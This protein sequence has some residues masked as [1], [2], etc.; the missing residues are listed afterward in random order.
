MSNYPKL[1]AQEAVTL[2]ADGEVCAMSGFSGV[3][4]PKDIP[5]AIAQRA[6][7]GSKNGSSFKIIELTGGALNSQ[8]DDALARAHAVS[9]CAPCQFSVPMRE[10]I[11]AHKIDYLDIHLSQMSEALSLCHLPRIQTAIIEVCNVSSTG[12]LTLTTSSGCSAQFCSMADR[13]LLELNEFHSKNLEKIHDV[14]MR[15]LTFPRDVIPLHTLRDRIGSS[16]LRV[17][18]GKIAGVVHTSGTDNLPTNNPRCVERTLASVV[19]EFLRKELSVGKLPVYDGVPCIE[20]GVGSMGDACLRELAFSE[21]FPPFM[22]FSPQLSDILFELLL[23]GRCLF[24]SGSC[25]AW[26]DKTLQRFY[27]SIDKF[28][29]KIILRPQDISNN[30]EVISRFGII[31]VNGAVEADICG[32][33]NSSHICGNAILNGIGGSGDFARHSALSIFIL[34]SVRKDGTISTIVPCVAHVD[35]TEHDVDI[36]I[37]EQ[38]IADLRGKTP[39][40]RARIVIENCAHPDYRALLQRY[41]SQVSYGHTPFSPE[42]AFSFHRALREGGDMR[43]AE[44]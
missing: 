43:A 21:D 22:T 38:G 27:N 41:F 36:L 26:C 8:Y 23:N 44:I 12:E 31:A 4:S 24:A 16:T 30:P 20:V 28:C 15:P 40:Q 35:H 7:E 11:N 13:I 5:L 17:D 6:K 19:H 32:N 25:L 34:P 18:P 42:K 2:I 29:D 33:V 10:E 1:T 3:G 14:Y 37:T 39:R 9:F